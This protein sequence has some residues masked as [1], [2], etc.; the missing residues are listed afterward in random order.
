MPIR[1]AEEG[2]TPL[3]PSAVDIRG[4]ARVRNGGFASLR[5]WSNVLDY[6]ESYVFSG[7][8]AGLDFELPELV[9]D[10]GIP[11]MKRVRGSQD[12]RSWRAGGRDS[13]AAEQ[14]PGRAAV[15]LR[16]HC[17]RQRFTCP[18]GRERD[19]ASGRTAPRLDAEGPEEGSRW[20]S[21]TVA[22]L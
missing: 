11:W 1:S 9:E 16:L 2:R 3:L 18:S 7:F 4:E 22:P 21:G 5:I 13:C 8:D 20:E 6:Q 15:S 19:S 12:H 10:P 14:E 17:R